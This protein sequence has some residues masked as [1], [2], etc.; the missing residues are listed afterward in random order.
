[1][2]KILFYY[3]VALC[4]PAS[5]LRPALASASGEF[6]VTRPAAGAAPASLVL[7]YDAAKQTGFDAQPLIEKSFPYYALTPEAR[8]RHIVDYLREAVTRMTGQTL[9]VVSNADLSA[10]LVLTLLD[11]ATPEIKKDPQVLRALRNTGQDSYNANEAFYIRS[12]PRRV[13]VVANTLDGL[14]DAVVELLESVGYEVLGMGPNWVYAPD[15]HHKPLAFNLERAGRPGFYI[16]KLWATSGQNYGVGTLMAPP[17]AADEAVYDSYRRWQLGTRM[18]GQSMPDF[19]GHALQAYHDAV[20]KRMIATNT[21]AGFLVEKTTLG[22]DAVRP[23]ASADNKGFLWIDTDAEG[24]PAVGKTFLS[25]GEKWIENPARYVHANLD[26]SVPLVR[27]VILDDLE[28]RSEEH[29]KTQPNEPFVFDT[30]PE[31][32][33]YA[34][35]AA[36]LYNPNWYPEY[37]KQEG[38]KFGQPYVLNGFKGLNQ[39]REL[40]DSNAAADIVFGFDNWLLREYDKWIDSLPKAERITASSK[41]KKAQVRISHY[42]YNYH[43]VPPDFNLD[44]R[45]RVMIASYP[46]HRGWGKWKNFKTQTDMAQAFQVMLPREPSGDYWIISLSYYWDAD[47]NHGIGGSPSAEAIAQRIRDEYAA[48]FRALSAET[49]FNFGKQGLEYYL[50]TKMLWNS[51]LTAAELDALRTRW[52]QR[53]FGEGWQ[54]MKRYYDFMAPE[55]FTVNAPNNWAKAIRFIEAADAKIDDGSA[56]QKRLDDVKQYWYFYYLMETGQA[57]PDSRAFREFVWKGQMSYMTAMHMVTRRFFK[58]GNAQDAAGAEFNSGPAHYTHEE[59]QAWWSKVLD[60]WQVTPVSDFADAKL[61]DGTP[62]RAVDVNDLVA[63]QEFASTPA[64]VPFLYNS[65]YQKPA[66][67]EAVAARAGETIGFQLFWPWNAADAYYR[68]RDLSYGIEVWDAQRK[69]WEPLVDKST[70]SVPSR[71]VAGPKGEAMQLATVRYAA[72]R[73]GTYRFEIGYGGNLARLTTLDYDL[74]TG[75]YSGVRGHTYFDNLDGLTQGPV[76]FYVPKGTKSIDLEVW[77]AYNSKQLQL[78]SGLPASGIKKTRVVDVSARGTHVVKLEPGED[79]SLAMLSGN[80]FSFPYLYSV[81]MLWAKS[82]AALL[83]PRAIAQA[84]GLTLLK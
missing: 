44:P 10:G 69:T 43:D 36:L 60:T 40:W 72:P 26:L 27:A 75:E 11:D 39:P 8:M 30:E 3:I 24:T 33:G 82:P 73:A 37:L 55:N 63:V 31:D 18:D 47:T 35:L 1:V 41:D 25:D 77:D 65:G 20:L 21:T 7:P 22:L 12:E 23:A 28:K 16:R 59:T 58:T 62:G 15:F 9:P 29:F 49:D 71:Q 45:I 5:T 74:A 78:Y 51:Q 68:Q 66:S 17:D 54:E 6:V 32:G 46:K 42:S 79:G 80:G 57:K 38:V 53:A 81:P 64:D 83:V 76:Y 67:F 48:G 13:L 52:L 70:T 50:Y 61:A 4:L 56:A 34:Q 84:D 2:N 14:G 19:P